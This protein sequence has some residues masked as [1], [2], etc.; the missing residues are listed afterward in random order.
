MVS[1]LLASFQRM[2]LWPH[3]SLLKPGE[4]A[5]MATSPCRSRHR[6]G[7][8]WRCQR[9]CSLSERGICSQDFTF[10]KPKTVKAVWYAWMWGQL[11]GHLPIGPL[12][13]AEHQ[14]WTPYVFHPLS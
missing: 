14:S 6:A 13:A 11:R 1:I 10:K 5:T 12:I 3:I 9:M 4:D 8:L 7:L 2:L